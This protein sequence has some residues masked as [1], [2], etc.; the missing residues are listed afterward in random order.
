MH[1]HVYLTFTRNTFIL[2][3]IIL[4]LS[5]FYVFSLLLSSSSGPCPPTDVSVS[6]ECEGNV[7]TVSWVASATADSYIATATGEDGHIH[8]CDSNGTSC[9]F[10]DLH[11]GESY[12]VSVVTLER[13]CQSEPSQPV[14]LRTG[15]Y[16]FFVC[17]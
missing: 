9:S 2:F 5:V 10:T 13:G 11:C 12:A 15:E 17:V 7:G 4:R 8:T 16:Y 3:K 6:L 14:T 1:M